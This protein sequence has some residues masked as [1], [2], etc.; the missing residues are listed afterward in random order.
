MIIFVNVNFINDDC[1]IVNSGKVNMELDLNMLERAIA[2]NSKDAFVRFYNWSPKCISL[3]KNQP[4]EEFYNDLGIDIVRRPTGGRAVLH[5]KE[6]TYCFVS[7]IKNG[8]SIIESYKEI[9]DAL[10]L[11]FKKLGIELNYAGER[12]KNLR[13]CMN[14]SCGADVSYMGKKLIGSAQ[15]RSRGYLL[16]HGSI[17]YDLD[18]E[19]VEKIFKQK[20]DRDSIITLSEIAQ[21]FS[22]DDIIQALQEGFREKFETS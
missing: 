2:T 18:F 12:S 7:P 6:L 10:I 22:Q 14:I 11:G 8:Q 1:N 20:V 16:Q 19:L 21:S 17:L 4:F 5:D 15:F 3:G 13:Y 9:S